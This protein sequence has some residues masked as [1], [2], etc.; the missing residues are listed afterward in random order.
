M[1]S[2]LLFGSSGVIARVSDFFVPLLSQSLLPL[3]GE[4]QLVTNQLDNISGI[5]KRR[6]SGSA[7]ASRA[8]DR[9]LAIANFGSIRGGTEV[10]GGRQKCTRGAC[11]PPITL[12]R[13]LLHVATHSTP[14]SSFLRNTYFPVPVL[15]ALIVFPKN[16]KHKHRTHRPFAGWKICEPKI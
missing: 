7:R 9:A 8:G 15:P 2:S 3:R 13:R 12:P 4:N 1:P 16:C 14:Q 11:A 10:F 6:S 5:P